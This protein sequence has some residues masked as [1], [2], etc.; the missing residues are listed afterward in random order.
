MGDS[1]VGLDAFYTALFFTII[2]IAALL[3]KQWV[4]HEKLVFPLAQVPVEVADEVRMGA[5]IRS[6]LMWLCFCIPVFIYV[7][8]AVHIYYPSFPDI[9]I[10]RD[11]GML[12][13]ARPW[14]TLNYLPINY[15]FDMMGITYLITTDV[16]FSFWFFYVVRRLQI[17][18]CAALG[19]TD[20]YQPL[21]YQTI[22]G[23]LTLF[24]LQLWIARGY[25]RD[26]LYTALRKSDDAHKSNEPISY[27]TLLLLIGI[28]VG[29]ILLWCHQLGLSLRWATLLFAIH[30]IWR[31][32]LTRMVAEAGLFVFWTPSPHNFLVR[33]FGKDVIGPKN[34]TGLNMV[35]SKLNDSATCLMPQ[36]LQGLKIA[37]T[38]SL[39]Q[40][41]VFGIL[42][43]STLVSMLTC[44][45][46]C[47]HIIY[48]T[49]VPKMGCWTRAYPRNMARTL[50]NQ[51]VQEQ[52]MKTGDY[53]SMLAGGVVTV[54]LGLL[55][56]RFL[57]WPFHP[58]GYVAVNGT[59]FGNRY[60]FSIFLGWLFKAVTLWFGGIRLWRMMRPAAMGLI[61]GNTFILFLLLLLH[62]FWPTNEVVVI[63]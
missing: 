63:E 13:S 59:W 9:D 42:L 31:T 53:I 25:L 10:Y 27:R 57:W 45:P 58:L 60:A 4:D 35:G 33:A 29:F 15:Y 12:F 8:R 2:G 14:N 22:G 20:Y 48:T 28:G 52:K 39:N 17:V 30:L 51:L 50:L 36:A 18:A 49:A 56:W 44:H 37:Q 23:L 41:Q 19:L 6:P 38:A 62:F 26:V 40:R 54:A 43:A 34:I 55:R 47:L 21:E 61:L 5:L 7:V 46:T 24:T 3:R 1:A 16:G 11:L 32:L